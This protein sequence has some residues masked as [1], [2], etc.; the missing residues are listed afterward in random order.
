VRLSGG[1]T[2]P[3]A[4]AASREAARRYRL[5]RVDDRLLHGQVALGWARVLRPRHFLLV[6]EAAAHD[7]DAVRLFQSV[8]PEETSVLVI[9]PD[10]LLHPSGLLPDPASTVLLVRGIAEAAVLLRA[11]IV[12]P[13]NLGGVHAHAGAREVYPFLYLTPLEERLLR[14]LNDE[15]F[16]IFAQDLP[17]N[18]RHDPGEWLEQGRS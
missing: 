13:V 16:E 15:G 14:S 10:E 7:P 4:E 1:R 12:A 2:G 11:G 8:A 17:Q 9:S 5:F 18:P 6:D 3:R